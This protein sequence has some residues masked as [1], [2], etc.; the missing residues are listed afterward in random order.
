MMRTP[1]RLARDRTAAAAA[2]LA[3]SLPILLVLAYAPMEMGNYFLTQHVVQKAAR[4]AAR[5]ASRLPMTSY[6]SCDATAPARE[7]IQ[8]VA[9]TGRPDG[10]ASNRIHTWTA[11]T[12]TTVTLFCDTSGTYSG[13]YSDFAMGAPKVTVTA[14]IPYGSIWGSLG[15]GAM[16]LSVYGRSEAAVFGA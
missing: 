16:N 2:E 5:Y 3:I 10:T 11:D 9:R 7:Q 15:F 1:L 12:M 4:D 6:P 13:V 8:R 14:A